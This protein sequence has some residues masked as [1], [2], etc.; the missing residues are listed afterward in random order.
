MGRIW[1]DAVEVQRVLN[2]EMVSQ[3]GL[4]ST[5]LWTRCVNGCG[6]RPAE[7]PVLRVLPLGSLD[8]PTHGTQVQF[9]GDNVGTASTA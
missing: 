4:S 6:G 8:A 9:F 2:C 3:F 7:T 1:M 5:R